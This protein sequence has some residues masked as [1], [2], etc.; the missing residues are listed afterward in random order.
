MPPAASGKYSGFALVEFETPT[1]DLE[2]AAQKLDAFKQLKEEIERKGG[3]GVTSSF[4]E[5]EVIHWPES[6]RMGDPFLIRRLYGFPKVPEFSLYVQVTANAETELT[7]AFRFLDRHC[8]VE[9]Y[10]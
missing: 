10:M 2:T 1:K 5:R 9:G 8:H 4:G 3:R 7:K 6:A